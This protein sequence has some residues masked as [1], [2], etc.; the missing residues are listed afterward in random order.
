MGSIHVGAQSRFVGPFSEG[1]KTR[2][3][4]LTSSFLFSPRQALLSGAPGNAA[5]AKRCLRDAPSPRSVAS[6]RSLA[7]SFSSLPLLSLVFSEFSQTF[8]FALWQLLYEWCES[9]FWF[10]KSC[11]L[12]PIWFRLF[13][14]G[15]LLHIKWFQSV[16]SC[17]CGL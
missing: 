1:D 8:L 14:E 16:S 15:F 11:Y 3:V 9:C 10:A 12:I 17:L 4:A 2:K 13:R 6:L 7:C 5:T